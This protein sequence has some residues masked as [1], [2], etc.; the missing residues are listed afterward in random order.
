MNMN[1]ILGI[2]LIVI[3]LSGI[4]LFPISIW[5]TGRGQMRGWGYFCK[6]VKL[7]KAKRITIEEFEKMIQERR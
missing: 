4:S 6:A 7:Y 3:L 5:L 1:L 2:K